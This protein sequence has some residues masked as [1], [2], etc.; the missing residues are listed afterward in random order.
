[1]GRLPKTSVCL[2]SQLSLCSARHAIQSFFIMKPHRIK[3]FWAYR[4]G[5]NIG[6]QSCE[7]E[8]GCE[9]IT[10]TERG[11]KEKER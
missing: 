9:T 11:R 7:D 5:D 2:A 1:M 10:G 4:A 6:E 8:W 3:F